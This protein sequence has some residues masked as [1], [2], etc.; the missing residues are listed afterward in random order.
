MDWNRLVERVSLSYDE[1]MIMWPGD[2]TPQMKD[3]FVRALKQAV[4]TPSVGLNLAQS[5]GLDTM[6]ERLAG[7]AW[8]G[9]SNALTLLTATANE[10]FTR[11]A[12]GY[13]VDATKKIHD[14]CNQQSFANELAMFR[15]GSFGGRSSPILGLNSMQ[16]FYLCCLLEIET[17]GLRSTIR[18]QLNAS[19]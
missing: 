9:G 18:P 12:M 2:W 16:T 1:A 8:K 14:D 10:L 13:L 11:P 19:H 6:M 7:A 17:Y 15:D 5:T 3:D 4:T